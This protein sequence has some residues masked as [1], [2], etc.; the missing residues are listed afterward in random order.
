M[1]HNREKPGVAF[2]A[3]VVVVAALAVYVGGY[4][5]TVSRGPILRLGPHIHFR[6]ATQAWPAAYGLHCSVGARVFAENQG[7]F[8]RVF[9]PLHW[10][11]RKLRATYWRTN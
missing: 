5:Y 9:A 3:T 10:V 4:R 11:D 6:G 7:T 8:R 2:W 1:S